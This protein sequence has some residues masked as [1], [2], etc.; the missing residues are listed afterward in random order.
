MAELQRKR[1]QN[2]EARERAYEASR[3]YRAANLEAVRALQLSWRQRNQWRRTAYQ[4]LRKAATI[5]RTPKWANLDAIAAIYVQCARITTETGVPHHV[6]H[7]YPLQGR[8]VSGLHV[9]TNLRIIPASDNC[10]KHNSMPEE[11]S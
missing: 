7:F 6:D 10:L 8:T 2:P 9:E 4:V 1:L 11:T 5:Q 3:R